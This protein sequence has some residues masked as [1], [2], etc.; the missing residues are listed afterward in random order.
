METHNKIARLI[1]KYRKGRLTAQEQRE[2]DEWLELSEF[3]R[4]LFKGLTDESYLAK[5]KEIDVN[6]ERK[7]IMELYKIETGKSIHIITIKRFMAAAVIFLVTAIGYWLCHPA[8]DAHTVSVETKSNNTGDVVPAINNNAEK[9]NE[10]TLTLPDNSIVSLDKVHDGANVNSVYDNLVK[11][12]NGFLKVMATAGNYLENGPEQRIENE[13]DQ[14]VK[15]ERQS[16]DSIGYYVLNIPRGRQYQITLSD[17]TKVYLNASSRLRF[18]TAFDNNKR[19]V[20]LTGEAYFEVS[21]VSYSTSTVTGREG[22]AGNKKVPFVVKTREENVTVLGTRFNIKAYD[23]E[24][25]IK[26]TLVE[27]LVQIEYKNLSKTITTGQQAKLNSNGKLTIQNNINIQEVLAWK[28]NLF[29]FKD[30]PLATIMREI[31]RWYDVEV[32]YKC[33]QS[34]SFQVSSRRDRPLADLLGDLEETQAVHF[35]IVGKRITVQSK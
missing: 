18:P 33:C 12:N 19:Y 8:K 31:S 4:N 5:L 15:N 28:D 11:V 26:T 32:F 1:I 16:T 14:R 3:N 34:T 10:V 22:Q 25:E 21:T 17:G 29:V 35:E 13:P 27:G 20:E 30:K 24:T 7:K 9:L 6:T 2:L 23:E